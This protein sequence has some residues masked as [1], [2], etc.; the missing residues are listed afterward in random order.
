VIR[1]KSILPTEEN[2]TKTEVSAAVGI[3]QLCQT[4]SG[5]QG[6]TICN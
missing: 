1:N 3:S 6:V 5:C 2:E 4:S